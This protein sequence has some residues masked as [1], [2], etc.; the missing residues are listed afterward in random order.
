M[1]GFVMEGHIFVLMMINTQAYQFIIPRTCT[2]GNVI[3]R[4]VVVNK[5]IA[6]SGDLGTR[7]SCKHNKS[8]KKLHG[9]NMLRIEWYSLQTSQIVHF[10]W[11]S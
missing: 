2:K 1:H 7:A 4:V 11:P 8:G 9:L 10:S 5:N 6:K 3:S